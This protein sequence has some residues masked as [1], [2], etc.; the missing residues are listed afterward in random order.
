MFIQLFGKESVSLMILY[1]ILYYTVNKRQYKP[2]Q[3]VTIKK[4]L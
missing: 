2:T 1:N 3:R 4:A